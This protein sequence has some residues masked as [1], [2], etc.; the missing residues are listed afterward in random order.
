VA[1]DR[2]QINVRVDQETD[3]MVRALVED[4]S[5]AAGC[6]VKTT[7]V[8]KAAVQALVEKRGLLGW[9][10]SPAREGGKS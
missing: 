9:P 8:I 5:Q 2:R 7:A 3:R 1:T 10:A 4:M 6:A